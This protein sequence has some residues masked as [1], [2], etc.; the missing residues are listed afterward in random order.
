MRIGSDKFETHEILEIE[1]KKQ[2]LFNILSLF[3]LT[4]WIIYYNKECNISI[5]I[6]G[7]FCNIM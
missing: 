7:F 2:Q 3:T 1:L 5:L 6:E 4:D